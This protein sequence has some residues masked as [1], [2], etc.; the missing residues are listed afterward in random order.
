[1]SGK[2]K[3]LVLS[4]LLMA[5]GAGFTLWEVYLYI[6]ADNDLG[7]SVMAAIKA[8]LGVVLILVSIVLYGFAKAPEQ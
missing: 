7:V 8:M 3:W 4:L 2:I 6:T 5:A 1:M